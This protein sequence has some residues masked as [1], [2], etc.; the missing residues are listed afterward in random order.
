L[1][2]ICLVRRN[3]VRIPHTLHERIT[4]EYN[5]K[6]PETGLRFRDTLKGKSFEEQYEI[7]I[8]KLR[9]YGVIE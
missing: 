5:E 1:E 7:G 9:K 3:I 4:A 6:D 8:E 2:G